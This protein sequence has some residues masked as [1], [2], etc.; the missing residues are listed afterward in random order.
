MNE[1]SHSNWPQL[2]TVYYDRFFKRWP[3]MMDDNGATVE[4]NNEKG[5][6]CF[7]NRACGIW[8]LW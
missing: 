7:M 4:S 6:K 5:A 8:I 3:A 2:L 1:L